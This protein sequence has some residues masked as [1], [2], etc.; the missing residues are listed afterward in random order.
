M[1][2]CVCVCVLVCLFATQYM[3]NLNNVNTH[4]PLPLL[5]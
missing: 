5:T 2:A 1:N 3:S 4:V